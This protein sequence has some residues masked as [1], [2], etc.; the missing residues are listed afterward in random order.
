M[1][2]LFRTTSFNEYYVGGIT[3]A[4]HKRTFESLLSFITGSAAGAILDEDDEDDELD[5]NFEDSERKDFFSGPLS[6][7]D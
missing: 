5:L 6:E 4:E 7:L 1:S 2:Q 3:L